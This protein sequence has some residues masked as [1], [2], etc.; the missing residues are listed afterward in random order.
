MGV[1]DR[2]PFVDLRDPEIRRAFAQIEANNQMAVVEHV[3][4]NVVENEDT[5]DDEY[6]GLDT[7][8]YVTGVNANDYD[9][10]NSQHMCAVSLINT[11]RK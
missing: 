11:I 3:M 9:T 2:F 6:D 10:D 1:C 7:F 4:A 8:E 5:S